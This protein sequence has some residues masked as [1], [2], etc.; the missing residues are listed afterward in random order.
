M[1]FLSSS[2]VLTFA[3]LCFFL[4]IV[5]SLSIRKVASKFDWKVFMGDRLAN[6]GVTKNGQAGSLLLLW[7][8]LHNAMFWVFSLGSGCE[9]L[10]GNQHPGSLFGKE[11]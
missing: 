9:R 8:G 3:L 6:G 1:R 7:K 10:P 11:D 5:L 4:L 2:F